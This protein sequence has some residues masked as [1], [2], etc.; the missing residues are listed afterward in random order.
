MDS[1]T[2]KLKA[3]VIKHLTKNE[4]IIDDKYFY[5]GEKFYSRRELAAEIESETETGIE[6]LTNMVILAIDL[7]ARQSH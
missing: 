1:L 6:I 4:Q 2:I 5:K 3:E 7:T